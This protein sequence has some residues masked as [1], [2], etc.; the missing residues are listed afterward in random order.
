MSLLEGHL[1]GV[2]A[3]AIFSADNHDG[4]VGHESPGELQTCRDAIRINAI[5]TIRRTEVLR[6]RRNH[7]ARDVLGNGPRD[8]GLGHVHFPARDLRVSDAFV[9]V[10]HHDDEGTRLG[11]FDRT[12]MLRM[13][14]LWAKE[15]GS[16]LPDFAGGSALVQALHQRIA[17]VVEGV[18]H[19]ELPASCRLGL[20]A[21]L[22]RERRRNGE[23]GEEKPHQKNDYFAHDAPPFVESHVIRGWTP[24]GMM[25]TI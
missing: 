7:F 8:A 3:E 21:V 5:D 23:D 12:G 15:L 1:V 10:P 20:F 18:N 11:L 2:D 9:H 24:S 6:F 13:P 19:H 4:L 17:G 14:E 22:L 16:L 25:G